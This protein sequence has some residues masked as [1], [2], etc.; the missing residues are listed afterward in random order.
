MGE[1]EAVD[2]E[3]ALVMILGASELRVHSSVSD[4][5]N[6]HSHSH[7]PSETTR[8]KTRQ[9]KTRQDKTRQ[10]KARKLDAHLWL[11]ASTACSRPIQ[12]ASQDSLG[13]APALGQLNRVCIGRDIKKL[14]D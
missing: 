3:R 14:T 12:S 6:S 10:D 7:L 8:D 2:L 9:D 4:T 5:L 11:A 1:R 13:S